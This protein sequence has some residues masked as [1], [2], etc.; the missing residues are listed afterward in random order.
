MQ[1]RSNPTR[2]RSAS[3]GETNHYAEEYA[4]N[5]ADKYDELVG[6]EQRARNEGD[7][8]VE[9]LRKRKVRR[10]L[11]VAAGTG[12]HSV[13]LLA[14]GFEVVSAD[15]S[16][17]MLAKAFE[18]GRRH[19]GHVLRTVLTDW[20]W[21]TRDI[22]ER[23]DAV[24]CLGNSFPH[25]FAEAER[26]KVL[27]EF[28]AALKHDGL[29]VLDQRNYDA[30]LEGGRL[31]R[32]SYCCSDDA[33]GLEPECV[34]EGL[35]TLRYHFPDGTEHRLNTYPLRKEETRSLLREAGF[36][37]VHTFGDFHETYRDDE[38]EFFVHLAKKS[39]CDAGEEIT[40]EQNT[41]SRRATL[42]VVEMQE[43]EA[44]DDGSCCSS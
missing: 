13:R 41:T 39:I 16:A 33:I 31:N 1:T 21:L 34:E 26:R 24:L 43:R 37:S 5:F 15:G 22:R 6:W 29:L 11:D 10:I 28:Y 20:R 2:L 14:A 18:N 3:A 9:H 23:Y 8:F 17:E 36:Q 12:F 35:V 30:I 38:P 19:G 25:L 44:E 42:P 32:R 40:E 7:F 27:A 4:E